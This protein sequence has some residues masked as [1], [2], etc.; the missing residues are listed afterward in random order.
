MPS[1][2]VWDR[3]LSRVGPV[4]RLIS[5]VV[6]RMV[7]HTTALASGCPHR[8]QW[9][10]AKAAASPSPAVPAP[11]T[12]DKRNSSSTGPQSRAV[13]AQSTSAPQVANPRPV[14]VA[15]PNAPPQRPC[16]LRRLR[17]TALRRAVFSGRAAR[18][19]AGLSRRAPGKGEYVGGIGG[20]L[21]CSGLLLGLVMCGAWIRSGLLVVTSEST[22]MQPT[23]A[24]GDRVLVWRFCPAG[25]VRRGQIV[26]IWPWRVA[27]AGIFTQGAL[28]GLPFIKR[29]VGLSGDQVVTAWA[30]LPPA[31][32]PQ[33]AG[34]Y[35]SSGN[36]TW[37]IPARHLFVC[38]DN[39]RGSVNYHSGGRLP[40]SRAGSRDPAPGPASGWGAARR[41]T[42]S[43]A[44]HA[45]PGPR[46]PL[47]RRVDTK[48]RDPL[49]VMH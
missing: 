28:P 4:N 26:L 6:E 49:Q 48:W 19:P 22:S 14:A 40:G 29:V 45:S 37:Q 7:P 13:P 20:V 24:P 27:P 11:R 38:G 8:A 10:A 34:E 15:D 44:N 43:P 35:D 46:R 23:L 21:S 41:V 31:H 1:S 12:S 42:P 33:P 5:Y 9:C 30:D 25:W 3:A 39:A 36:R 47:R 16:R 32:Q 2:P 17:S 18:R